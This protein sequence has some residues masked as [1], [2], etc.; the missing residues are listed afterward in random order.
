MPDG[1]NAV[2]LV[3]F[4]GC[5]TYSFAWGKVDGTIVD[6]REMASS[7]KRRKQ[8]RVAEICPRFSLGMG[9]RGNG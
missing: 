8:A 7:R 1:G 6:R 9:L 3:V 5:G 4:G 2:R